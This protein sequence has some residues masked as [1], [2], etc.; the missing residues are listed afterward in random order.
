MKSNSYSSLYLPAMK[1]PSKSVHS[2]RSARGRTV[3]E[4]ICS[5][6]AHFFGA[7]KPIILR[8]N[9]L[10]K[11]F[12]VPW[13]TGFS[14]TIPC[15]HNTM[16]IRVVIELESLTMSRDGFSGR[17]WDVFTSSM[18]VLRTT[19]YEFRYLRADG[20]GMFFFSGTKNVW[21]NWTIRHNFVVMP[22]LYTYNKRI[23]R[24]IIIWLVREIMGRL[25]TL[26]GRFVFFFY[27]KINYFFIIRYAYFFFF[28]LRL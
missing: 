10:R 24:V 27:K 2:K 28:V 20:W 18:P 6:S 19:V 22:R 7:R 4:H 15:L 17:M 5:R 13:R 11:L 12:F 9:L 8:K 1:I 14:R 16:L 21:T 23:Y 26:Q 3:C 25:R